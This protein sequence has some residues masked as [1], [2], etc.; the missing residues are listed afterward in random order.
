MSVLWI[1]STSSI[2]ID[3]NPDGDNQEVYVS[4]DNRPIKRVYFARS[5]DGGTSW[6]EPVE[7]DG[8]IPTAVNTSPFNIIVRPNGNHILLVWQAGLQSGFDC[9]QYYQYSQDKGITWSERQVMLEDLVGCP[10]DNQFFRTTDGLDL[11]STTIQDQV[12]LLAWD[13]SKWSTPQPQAELYSFNDP[14]TYEAVNFRCRKMI[15]S[16]SDQIKA[17]GCNPVGNADV[18]FTSRSIGSTSDWFPPASEWTKPVVITSLSGEISSPTILTDSQERLHVFWIQ[19]DETDATNPHREIFYTRKEGDTWAQPAAV[20]KSPDGDP[21]HLH[22]VIDQT[23]RLLVAWNDNKSG[24]IYFSWADTALAS[25]VNEW[26][27][28]IAVPSPAGVKTSPEMLVDQQGIVY[29]AYTI[30][31]NETRGVYI[32]KSSDQGITWSDPTMIFDAAAAGW[33]MVD[34]PVMTMTENNNLHVIWHRFPFPGLNDPVTLYYSRSNDGGATWSEPVLVT[35]N[36]VK[37]STIVGSGTDLVHRIWESEDNEQ[38]SMLHDYSQDT[39][40]SWNPAQNISKFGEIPGPAVGILDSTGMLHLVDVSE[41]SSGS[42]ML[43]HSIWNSGAWSDEEGLLLDKVADNK[44]N[45]VT[46]AISPDGRLSVVYS[47]SLNPE[48]G[49]EE[50]NHLYYTN[51]LLSAPQ[52]ATTPGATEVVAGT[53]WDY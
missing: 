4:W 34:M 3:T 32:V 48:S 5:Q 20:L 11:L 14:D 18:W 30:P 19:P 53:T 15:M 9:T 21:V 17:V 26:N 27:K 31:L 28:P 38:S 35:E 41:L 13:G 51:I 50:L 46:A 47:G 39:G 7:V 24:E 43:D 42:Q 22:A 40:A 2:H 8:P 44:V 37:W 33:D 6:T 12:Y 29:I 52:D 10:Q 23:G 49:E 25:S 1:D 16:G 45:D 36:S